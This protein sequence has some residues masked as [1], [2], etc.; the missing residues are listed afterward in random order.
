MVDRETQL[1]A[2][3]L[4]RQ[5]AQDVGSSSSRIKRA[6][7]VMIDETLMEWAAAAPG[8]SLALTPYLDR[9]WTAGAML[10]FNALRQ[11]LALAMADSHPGR[12]EAWEMLVEG[13]IAEGRV[14]GDWH[15]GKTRLTERTNRLLKNQPW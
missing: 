12:I 1:R 15:L 13:V 9:A 2:V 6:L 10:E 8:E 14:T 7:D 11:N 3:D 4:L 5:T